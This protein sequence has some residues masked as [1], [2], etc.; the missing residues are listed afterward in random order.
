MSKACGP[1]FDGGNRHCGNA[2]EAAALEIDLGSHLLSL[3]SVLDAG[4]V[5][6]CVY[7]RC[8]P[9]EATVNGFVAGRIP[10]TD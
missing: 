10:D 8:V 2:K 6:G 9:R 3:L 1:D 4:Q 5:T 7:P